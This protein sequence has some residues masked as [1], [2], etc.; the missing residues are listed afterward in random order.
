M[1]EA[2][3]NFENIDNALNLCE[4]IKTDLT[5]TLLS[6]QTECA[7]KTGTDDLRWRLGP[8]NRI[9]VESFL[10]AKLFYLINLNISIF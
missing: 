7:T 4:H 8:G 9:G 3:Q 10:V 6:L 5:W 2:K 1:D